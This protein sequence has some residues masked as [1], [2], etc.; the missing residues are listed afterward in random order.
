MN[1]LLQL[2]I[3]LLKHGQFSTK[4]LKELLDDAG[5]VVDSYLPIASTLG[6]IDFIKILQISLDTEVVFYIN[7]L[8]PICLGYFSGPLQL[9][10]MLFFQIHDKGLIMV[11][12]AA[13]LM[14]S[15]GAGAA[16]CHTTYFLCSI[17]CIFRSWQFQFDTIFN[18]IPLYLALRNLEQDLPSLFILMV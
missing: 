18:V 7:Q 2:C 13:V 4:F 10:L 1:I 8:L 11:T 3:L 16:S 6:V 5:E 14:L 15:V 9:A 12:V 17:L